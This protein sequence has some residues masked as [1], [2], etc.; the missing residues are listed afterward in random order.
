[1]TKGEARENLARCCRWIGGIT[2]KE[3][4]AVMAEVRALPEP[5]RSAM[6]VVDVT[7]TTGSVNET[8]I[9]G[10]VVYGSAVAL[11]F[12]G[13]PWGFG[14][15]ASRV[16]IRLSATRRESFRAIIVGYADELQKYAEK[17]DKEPLRASRKKAERDEDVSN[18]RAAVTGLRAIAARL[19]TKGGE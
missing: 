7:R 6:L 3:V 8:D 14:D 1:M 18:V 13:D 16:H 12:G 4:E 17:R 2:V 10:V 9:P 5:A 19:V 15:G 11:S